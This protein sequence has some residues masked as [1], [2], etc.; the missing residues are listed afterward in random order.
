M[1][2]NTNLPT[3]YS[4]WAL[5]NPITTY[6]IS[7]IYLYIDNFIYPYIIYTGIIWLTFKIRLSSFR[8]HTVFSFM[9]QVSWNLE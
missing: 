5:N 9:L 6:C 2:S 7:G 4:K 3:L 8:M 1:L